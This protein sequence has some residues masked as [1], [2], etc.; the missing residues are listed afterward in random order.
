MTKSLYTIL[1]TMLA[2]NLGL[3][4]WTSGSTTQPRFHL[5]AT[6][7]ED[8]LFFAGG[9][10]SPQLEP[11][12]LVEIYNTTNASWSFDQLSVARSFPAAVASVN[13]VF[14][15]GGMNIITGENYDI[16]DIYD[17]EN[18]S[19]SQDN[20]SAPRNAVTAVAVGD[21][22]L[23][24]GGAV[25]SAF[26]Q[27]YE[28]SDVVDIYDLTNDVW[29]TEHLSQARFLMGA[30]VVGDKA[31]FA[32]GVTDND[33]ES[34]RVDIYDSTTGTW[35]VDSLSEA[36][37][38]VSA[39]S[40]DGKA[41]F[42]GG[43][44]TASESSDVIDIYDPENG[45]WEIASLS[46]PRGVVNAVTFCGKAYFIAGGK[47]NW[48]I[49]VIVDSQ[50]IIDVYDPVS[51]SWEVDLLPFRRTYGAVAANEEE[52]V[53][54]GGFDAESANIWA[55][56]DI[57]NCTLSSVE[58]VINQN[59]WQIYPNPGSSSKPLGIR[60][61]N[62]AITPKNILIYNSLGEVVFEKSLTGLESCIELNTSS[63][64]PGNIYYVRILALGG[65][66]GIKS[67]VIH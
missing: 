30:T 8:Q 12:D 50:D 60:I 11:S 33:I 49:K 26:F 52:L 54:V 57:L 1:F 65:R 47:T 36:R 34:N 29:T 42:A 63:L 67:I 13:K 45:S 56:A 58:H 15:A 10:S 46:V 17:V 64:S 40:L 61:Q 9:T 41:Y 3:T 66:T 2:I 35:M 23:F 55:S 37:L 32:G 39:L 21:K 25:L 24:A 28:T 16:V 18:E 22:I 20:L 59:D 62:P 27:E 48:D 44:N 19:W 43:Q 51:D 38:F 5:A 4:Q 14:F 31:Y 6:A 7:L 53:I